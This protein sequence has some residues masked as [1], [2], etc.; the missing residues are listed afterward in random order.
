M[1]LHIQTHKNHATTSPTNEN[2]DTTDYNDYEYEY[3]NVDCV[4][5]HFHMKNKISYSARFYFISYMI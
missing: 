3:I 5:A 4:S 1:L 2:R